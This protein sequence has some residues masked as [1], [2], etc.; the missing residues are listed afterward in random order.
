MVDNLDDFYW[1]EKISQFSKDTPYGI[2]LAIFVEP[3]LQYVLD[4][5]KTVESR[6]SINHCAPHNRVFS[7]DVLLLKKSGGPIVGMCEVS[8]VWFYNLD[9]NSWS[10][11]RRE[12]TQAL[13][14][15]D[16]EFWSKR[17]LASFATLMKIKKP[18][19]TKPVYLDKRDRRGWV[20]LKQRTSQS[21]L[22]NSL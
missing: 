19:K 11:I 14:A 18:V 6:F 5:K 1:E 15:Q 10:E 3:Y 16:P 20:V 21:S 2:H 8:N 12:F 17:K 7:G 22:D 4:G 13:C 9:K